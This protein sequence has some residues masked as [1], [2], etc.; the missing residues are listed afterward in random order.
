MKQLSNSPE[1]VAYF[2]GLH[3]Q[4][5]RNRMVSLLRPARRPSTPTYSGVPVPRFAQALLQENHR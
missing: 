5:L 3:G 4:A 1:A 2:T